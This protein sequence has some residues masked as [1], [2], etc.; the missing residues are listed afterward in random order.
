[1][2]RYMETQLSLVIFSISYFT[3]V[4]IRQVSLLSCTIY[5]TRHDFKLAYFFFNCFVIT[6]ISLCYVPRKLWDTA[7]YYLVTNL[8][9]PRAIT[10]II[11]S[12]LIATIFLFWLAFL[13]SFF[14]RVNNKNYA[15]TTYHE[16]KTAWLNARCISEILGQ[17]KYFS[18]I[19]FSG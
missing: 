17:I 3:R 5:V 10:S 6:S 2:R 13:Y 8:I 12:F 18:L 19:A 1:M 11:L 16:R 4:Q 7:C 15:S 9:S 14:S